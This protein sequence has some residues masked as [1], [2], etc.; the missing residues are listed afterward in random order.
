MRFAAIEM[1]SSRHNIFSFQPEWIDDVEVV[2]SVHFITRD[3]QI[4]RQ[5]LDPILCGQQL[6]IIIVSIL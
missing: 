6:L 1:C 2:F 5:Q 4:Y 3:L